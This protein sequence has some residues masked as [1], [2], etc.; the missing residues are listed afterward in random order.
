MKIATT[1][2]GF[3]TPSRAGLFDLLSN[4]D[5]KF[6]TND[7][8]HLAETKLSNLNIAEDDDAESG[9]DSFYKD[10]VLLDPPPKV[11]WIC[12]D[13]VKVTWTGG[14]SDNPIDQKVNLYLADPFALNPAVPGVKF[15][16][17]IPMDF[18]DGQKVLIGKD[19]SVKGKEFQFKVDC[20]KY[21]NICPKC[22]NA[23]GKLKS[24]GRKHFK[25]WTYLRMEG[26]DGKLIARSEGSLNVAVTPF[27]G[28]LSHPEDYIWSQAWYSLD[29]PDMGTHMWGLSALLATRSSTPLVTGQVISL[30]Y[31]FGDWDILYADF[32]GT[33]GG[34]VWKSRSENV[35]SVMFRPTITF[36]GLA[37]EDWMENFSVSQ[38]G[39]DGW[40]PDCDPAIKL[41]RGFM[42]EYEMDKKNI[43]KSV[44]DAI[45]QD[46]N[47]Q[48]PCGANLPEGGH[49]WRI[50]FG[51][52]SQGA[53]MTQL[54]IYD[55]YNYLNNKLKP[56]QFNKLSFFL[57]PIGV[58]PAGNQGYAKW[59]ETTIPK[60]NRERFLTR[61]DTK[62][63][64]NKYNGISFH[65][66]SIP[67]GMLSSLVSIITVDPVLERCMNVKPSPEQAEDYSNYKTAKDP[68]LALWMSG[69]L[70]SY[71]QTNPS[72][73]ASSGSRFNLDDRFPSL[74]S[75]VYVPWDPEPYKP[76]CNS[77][78]CKGTEPI[79]K[80]GDSE[81]RQE[82]GI[83]HTTGLISKDPQNPKECKTSD[84]PTIMDALRCHDISF[85]AYGIQQ[86]KA[87]LDKIEDFNTFMY[88]GEA[89]SGCKATGALVTQ[90]QPLPF[91][92]K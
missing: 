69:D 2:T 51:G 67:S 4:L 44:M 53:G 26:S 59:V 71:I 80:W 18:L 5:V 35:I 88:Q 77:E 45:I 29:N 9:F 82:P 56:E 50:L 83:L 30:P 54:A 39:C 22:V 62:D 25:M 27:S 41:H 76:W 68:P 11:D 61:F 55:M 63:D 85:Y 7:N 65:F 42:Y 43:R 79:D 58:P 73:A 17:N 72:C 28:E 75:V 91:R 34:S 84:N 15:I 36:D 57:Y 33:L 12:N 19:I 60:T 32:R 52:M 70:I 14:Q 74:S 92:E 40:T 66:Q 46:G 13:T 89:F 23:D 21:I 78:G 47:L 24:D 31:G 10:L 48:S 3:A 20:E 37:Y 64:S 1:V 38:R 86:A 87:K 90:Q 6:E 8:E 49:A 16:K 81:H